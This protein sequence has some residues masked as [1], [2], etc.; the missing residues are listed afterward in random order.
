[1]TLL[2]SHD[3]KSYRS[4]SQ[5]RN[6]KDFNQQFEMWA[7]D[8]KKE[9]T[10]AQYNF[11]KALIRY[12]AFEPGISTAKYKTVVDKAKKEYNLKTSERTAQRIMP[13]LEQFGIVKMY[14]TKMERTK[15]RGANIIVWQR[16]NA[17][18]AN[19]FIQFIKSENGTKKEEIVD[20]LTAAVIPEDSENGGT[21]NIAKKLE[22]TDISAPIAIQ[23]NSDCGGTLNSSSKTSKIK[24]YIRKSVI[25]SDIHSVNKDL[26][27]S[28]HKDLYTLPVKIRGDFQ[29]LKFHSRLKEVIYRSDFNNKEDVTAISEIVYAN[30]YDLTKFNLYKTMTKSLLEKALRIVEVCLSSHKKGELDYIKSMRGFIDSRIKLELQAVT[31]RKV[32]ELM[33]EISPA[34]SQKV[35]SVYSSA[36]SKSQTPLYDWLNE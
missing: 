32:D 11:I 15:I 18:K 25:N 35:V 12:M 24:Y 16:Y 7:A 21:E 23:E 6:L 13:L 29:S 3:P 28:P 26:K 33:G 1:M 2:Y 19:A 27:E 4:L 10:L 30:I 36:L 20:S 8:I 14:A 5:F 31:E 22:I 34:L 9:I 17:K